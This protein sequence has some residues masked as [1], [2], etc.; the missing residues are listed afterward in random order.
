MR[1]MQIECF[2]CR[3][4]NIGV[5]LHDPQT[6]LTASIDAPEESAVV[7]AAERRGWTIS[8][9]FVTHHHADHV[10]ANLALKERYGLVIIGP[11]TEAL[12][13]PGID[14]MAS[15]GSSFRFGSNTVEVVET[16]GHTTG[17]VCYHI[18]HS[19]L[20]L[21]GD[22]LFALGCGRLIENSAADMWASLQKL[23]AL[24]DE[25]IVYFGHEYT[26]NNARF[27]LTI[28]PENK[29][30]RARYEQICEIQAIGGLTAPTTLGLEKE[31]NPFLR[32]DD[33]AIKALLGMQEASSAEVFAEIRKRRNNF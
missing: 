19:Q 7:A 15:G 33:P 14:R 11:T 26:L 4:D 25:T 32:V 23:T 13:I 31:T 27:A 12:K 30:L 6:Q 22:T 3:Q 18:P 8:H 9:I 2:P 24:P 29:R 10:E 17:H 1:E 16:P 21:T 28:D 5:L 20:L